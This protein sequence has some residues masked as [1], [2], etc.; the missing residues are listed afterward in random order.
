[1]FE[2][3]RQKLN[4]FKKT[5]TNKEHELDDAE[6]E[7]SSNDAARLA[8]VHKKPQ[9]RHIHLPLFTMTK[10]SES[11]NQLNQRRSGKCQ[12]RPQEPQAAD[13]FLREK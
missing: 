11:L 6:V 13:P 9:A 3:L 7:A 4:Q 8:E 10:Q 2:G 1:M 5:V 12:E